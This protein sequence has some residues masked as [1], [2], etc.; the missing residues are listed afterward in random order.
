[1]NSSK[2]FLPDNFLQ[3]LHS[4]GSPDLTG[5]AEA[6]QGEP[7]VSIRVNKDK[8]FES[9]FENSERVGWCDNG[10]YLKERPKFTL[11]PRMHQGVYYVQDASSMIIT[12]IVK[13]LL[14]K[15]GP[16]SEPLI[17]L[18]ACAAPGGKTTALIDALPGESIIVANE[19][20][21]SRASILRENTSKWGK[22]KIRITQWDA[23]NFSQYTNLFD[24]ILADAPC[25]G[26]GMMRKDETAVSQWS[27]KL[28]D[29]C[30][31]R[32]KEIVL[33]LWKALK[34]G[35][36]LIYSTCTFNRKENEEIAEW[37]RTETGGVSIGIDIEER[38]GISKGIKTDINCMRFL[39]NKLK[40]EGLFVT[41]FQKT[42]VLNGES[43]K[44]KKN[45]KLKQEVDKSVRNWIKTNGSVA[46]T[47]DEKGNVYAEFPQDNLPDELTPRL[48]IGMIKG[49]DILPS[50][51]LAMSTI[52]NRGVF[53]EGELSYEDAIKYL[54]GE[55][56]TPK[57][58]W[59][60]G[61]ILFTYTNRPLGFAK[62]LGSRANNLY[63][64]SWRIVQK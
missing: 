30:S 16:N 49:R 61:I 28:I 39:P 29:Q 37:I 2:R 36:Y 7:Y 31:S 20:S 24:I 59:E 46:Y 32:Q 27:E 41:I 25:S 64:D 12:H 50:Q 5:L 1:M 47:K 4:Y 34:P 8:S 22:G 11:D 45:R 6:L 18:D 9:E 58:E 60:K 57:E 55:C 17:V 43:R 54:K 40:G 23:K 19:L 15:S 26:E 3:L 44:Q 51:E 53:P 56:I 13:E 38:W 21:H 42:D 10:F 63:P 33:N 52:F 14:K 62:N 48:K 35:G